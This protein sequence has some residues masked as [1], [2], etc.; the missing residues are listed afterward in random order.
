MEIPANA[1]IILEKV[2]GKAM[3]LEA[4]IDPGAAREVGLCVLRSPDSAE[5]TRLSLFRNHRKP[6]T[7]SLQIDVS[8]ASLRGDAFGRTP[9]TGPLHLEDGELL[10]LRV[11]VDRSIVEVFANSRQCL[12]LRTYPE[13]EDSSGVS[14]FARGDAAKLVSLDAWHMHSIWSE[15]KGHE[16]M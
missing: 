14:V 3:E 1:E 9:E 4:V 16:G 5:L 2:R 15:L 13:R 12:T 10:R 11:F 8:A 7:N 6:G